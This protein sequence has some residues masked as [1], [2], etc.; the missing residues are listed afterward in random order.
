MAFIRADLHRVPVTFPLGEDGL[1]MVTATTLSLRF[2]FRE[3]SLY[4]EEEIFDSN[5]GDL[6]HA[7]GQLPIKNAEGTFWS[8]KPGKYRAYGVSESVLAASTVLLI[9]SDT[10]T[11][12]TETPDLPRVQVEARLETIQE[13]SDD[14]EN[15][16]SKIGLSKPTYTPKT[17]PPPS[18]GHQRSST[19]TLPALSRHSSL[20]SPSPSI[21]VVQSLIKL[22]SRKRSKNILSRVDYNAIKLQQVEF[23]P[24]QYD[25]DVIFEFPP[26]G[27]QG[28]QTA[29]KQL[30]GMDKRYDGHAWTRTITSNI[31]NDLDLTFRT[32]SC[33]GHLRCENVKCN[34][35]IRQHRTCPVNET[36]WDGVSD[37][38]FD[39]GSVPPAGSTVVCK[40]CNIPPTCLA[41]CPAKIYYVSAKV[42]MTRACVHL[43]SHAHPVKSGDHR[44]VIELTETL[45]GEQVE[46]NPSATRSSIVLETAKEIIGP[47]LLVGEGQEKKTLELEELLPIFDLCKHLTSPNLRNSISSFRYFRR[48]GVMDSIALLRGSSNWNFVQKNMFPGQGEDTDKVFLFKMSEVGPGSGVDLVKRMQ[49]GGDLENA[50]IMFDHV[51]RVKAWTTMACHVYD[52]TYCRVMTIAMCDMQSE[53]AVAQSVL[54]KNL[55]TVM[56]RHGVPKV[57][58]KGFMADSAQANW[59]AVRIIYGSGVASEIMQD[60]ERT[61]LFHWTQSLD[62]HTKADIRQDLQDQH[63][64]LCKQYK[65]ARTMEEAE[66][67]YSAIQAWWQSSCAASEAGL[68]RL[69]LWLAFWHFRYRQWGGFMELVSCLNFRNLHLRL[70]YHRR[71]PSCLI[72][73]ICCC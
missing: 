4:V 31:Q 54:W 25:G 15:E 18:V 30:I 62:K 33:L 47:L 55:N 27:F 46:R 65:N 26:T 11:V 39:I 50:W 9:P 1:A 7:L 13:L 48:Y 71:W 61:C 37:K 32:S 38:P 16:E 28:K 36:E 69:Q 21:S 57:N 49:V 67:R 45:I 52:S 53:D 72:N 43:G 64:K 51:K 17:S 2:Q 10:S 8:L 70:F 24:P 12:R 23:L 63:R 60:K 68:A 29:A 34:Y 19:K 40:S 44:E 59:N 42:D 56:A 6:M 5:S 41:L 22:S 35:L 3:D 66:T 73:V 20:P 14:S 58:F